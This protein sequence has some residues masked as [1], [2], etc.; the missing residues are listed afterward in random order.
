MKWLDRVEGGL[1]AHALQMYEFLGRLFGN[2]VLAGTLVY[3]LSF[4]RLIWKFLVREACS[5][6]EFF[7]DCSDSA[8][9]ALDDEQFLLNDEQFFSSIPNVRHYY[10]TSASGTLATPT[11]GLL[12]AADAE[13]G[14]ASEVVS[15]ISRAASVMSFGEGA[16]EDG[17][18]DYYLEG[19]ELQYGDPNRAQRAAAR[20][21]AAVEALLHQYDRA[22]D[23]MRAGFEAVVPS[24]AI[25][26]MR[27][28]DVRQRVCG[29]DAATVA[30]ILANSD[31]TGLDDVMQ[32]RFTEALRIMTPAAR[33]NF[34]V[35]AT[36][37]RRL[38][39]PEKI[40]LSCGDDPNELPTAHTCSPISVMIQPYTTHVHQF[41]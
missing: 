7:M 23:R 15:N 34:L 35:F 28:D 25:E 27:W 8:R 31:L 9:G 40:R 12:N 20:R 32:Q 11:M 10:Q 26:Q 29:S 19:V 39:V 30:D 22:L 36:G 6:E 13:S 4:P 3:A 41:P 1:D 21:S 18:V 16:T 5:I 2:A 38:P 17:S 24:V 33:S 14:V 37:Q